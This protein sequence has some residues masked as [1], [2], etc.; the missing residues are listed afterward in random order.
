MAWDLRQSI[1]FSIFDENGSLG[2]EMGVYG[3]PET[4]IIDTNGVIIDKFV[5]ALNEND[6]RTKI[7][8]QM[9]NTNSNKN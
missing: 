4:F 6:I 7:I 2:L 9:L 5:G 1:S 8:P 3:V